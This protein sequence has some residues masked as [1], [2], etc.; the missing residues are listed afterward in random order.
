MNNKL[1]FLALRAIAKMRLAL[2][3][4]TLESY[5]GNLLRI[6]TY[7]RIGDPNIDNGVLDPSMVCAT[8]KQFE[9]QISY[10]SQS[11]HFLSIHDL[12]AAI[13]EQKPLPAQS[14]MITFDDG[15]RDFLEF[16]W[17]ILEHYQVPTLMFLPTGFISQKNKVFWWDQLYQGVFN[18]KKNSLDLPSSQSF[19][20]QTKNQRWDS[21]IRLK[22]LVSGM[23]FHAAMQLVDQI[24]EVLEI[25][26]KNNGNIMDWSDARFLQDHGCYLA[27]H[28]VNHPIL[29][30]IT[31]TQARQEIHDSRQEIARELGVTWPVLAYPSGHEKDLNNDLW[32]ILNKEGIIFGMTS[33]PGIN[34]FPRANLLNLRRIEL[35]PRLNFLE[36]QP[37][38]TGIYHL[39]CTARNFLSP[40]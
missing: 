12:L 22:R 15:Y 4:R 3:V 24:M 39:T 40:Q 17:P 31:I 1:G 10:L 7:H 33:I 11:Y 29:S 27:A 26:P 37:L 19:S 28:T 32:P 9:Q 2:F 38:L 8:P 30:R 36:F 14:V 23:D 25:T 18:T 16:A 13:K 34:I 21:F 5:R 35:S 20:L 6:L